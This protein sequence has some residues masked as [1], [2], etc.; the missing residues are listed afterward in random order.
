VAGRARRG[1]GR[2]SVRRRALRA[3]EAPG[4]RPAAA[5]AMGGQP[6]RARARWSSAASAAP[7][8]SA[9]GP[10]ATVPRASS[11]ASRRRWRPRRRAAALALAAARA[12]VD[13]RA[14]AVRDLERISTWRSGAMREAALAASDLART[15]TD[16]QDAR[17]E[18]ARAQAE[19]GARGPT[20]RARSPSRWAHSRG[21]SPSPAPTSGCARIDSVGGFSGRARAGAP[22]G[23]RDRRS[24]PMRSPRR[25]CGA[26]SPA[27]IPISRSVRA[28]SGT[29]GSIAGRSRLAL[30]ALLASGSGGACTR[31]RPRE[32]SRRR[33]WLR[34]RIPS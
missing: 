1:A 5:V 24:P 31:R 11:S 12:D 10:G 28:S 7:A 20:W 32:P 29:R 8:C 2:R 15:R 14:A 30:P 6:R 27:C 16:V 25:T 13:D 19:L 22:G 9:R 26:R 23:D 21:S 4:G 34:P 33:G 17:T 3:V 18:L